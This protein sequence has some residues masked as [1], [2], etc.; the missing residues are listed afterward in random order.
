MSV[1][2]KAQG[3]AIC[4]PLAI[5]Q[6][7]HLKWCDVISNR[8]RPAAWSTVPTRCPHSLNKFNSTVKKLKKETVVATATEAS[9]YS[10][11]LHILAVPSAR[12]TFANIH[13]Q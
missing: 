9:S 13:P 2:S 4:I 11:G 10:W 3:I 6:L 7:F 5:N 12:G 8:A 1:F